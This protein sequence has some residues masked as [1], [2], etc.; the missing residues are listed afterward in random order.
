MPTLT[1][2]IQHSTKIFTR[3]IKKDKEIK[4]IQSRKEEVKCLVVDDIACKIV[5]RKCHSVVPNSCDPMDSSLPGASVHGIFQ[6]RILERVAILFSRGSS[7]PRDQT[8]SSTLQADSLSSE[9]P[10]K[11]LRL[12]QKPVR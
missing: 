5:L 7:R 2:L 11:P 6:A 12:H 8:G 1:I 10:G 9:P 4:G 3:V